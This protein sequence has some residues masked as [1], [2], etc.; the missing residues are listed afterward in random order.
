MHNWDLPLVSSF[1]IFSGGFMVRYSYLQSTTSFEA[2]KTDMIW[3]SWLGRPPWY[4]CCWYSNQVDL[5]DLMNNIT[6]ASMDELVFWVF[7]YLGGGLKEWLFLSFWLPT[8]QLCG[9][10]TVLQCGWEYLWSAKCCPLMGF[11]YRLV[12]EIKTILFSDGMGYLQWGDCVHAAVY[13]LFCA[14]MSIK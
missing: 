6:M 8:S 3:F 9:S 4:L 1:L 13:I 7:F 10:P 11:M 2:I 5:P 12:V 14:H